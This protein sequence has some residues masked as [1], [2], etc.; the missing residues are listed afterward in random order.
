MVLELDQTQTDNVAYT[1]PIETTLDSPRHRSIRCYAGEF[2][3]AEVV[4]V[5][6]WAYLIPG[7]ESFHLGQFQ[8]GGACIWLLVRDT[9]APQTLATWLIWPEA[10]QILVKTIGLKSRQSGHRTLRSALQAVTS[11]SPVQWHSVAR[12]AEARLAS[13]SAPDRAQA[14]AAELKAAA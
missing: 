4:V 2:T 12:I 5:E 9:E 3:A 13:R 6:A 14:P 11:A 8:D 7:V 10:Q 1:F